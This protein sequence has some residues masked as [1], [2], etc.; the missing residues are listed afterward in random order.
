MSGMKRTVSLLLRWLLPLAFTLTAGVAGAAD[1]T[2][3]A[4][5]Q[6]ASPIHDR[7]AVRGSYFR[8]SASTDAQIDDTAGG[9][10]GTPFSAED[11]F[12]L[13]DS[14][15]QGRAEF[16]PYARALRIGMFNLD[17]KGTVL[18]TRTF[19]YGDQ[20]FVINDRVTS[21]FDWR[22]SVT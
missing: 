13:A 8:G 18:L 11:D 17:R 19:N 3:S 2:G 1:S 5:T 20:T 6:T 14:V 21:E 22:M 9:R 15:S 12:G 10:T 4:S 16:N 7:F